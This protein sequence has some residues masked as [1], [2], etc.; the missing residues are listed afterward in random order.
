MT[1][2][3]QARKAVREIRFEHGRPGRAM[4][5]TASQYADTASDVWEPLLEAAYEAIR[6]LYE[7][8]GSAPEWNDRKSWVDAFDTATKDWEPDW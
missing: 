4:N 6:K 3:E 8:G 7:N 5:P 1:P 2:R